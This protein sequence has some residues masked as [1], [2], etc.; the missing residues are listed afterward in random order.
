MDDHITPKLDAF[1]SLVHKAGALHAELA[2]LDAAIR[3]LDAIKARIADCRDEAEALASSS[4]T[5][6]RAEEIRHRQ[7]GCASPACVASW[8][9]S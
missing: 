3:E 9:P 6:R 5:L 7:T 2:T 4:P 1:R 8:T